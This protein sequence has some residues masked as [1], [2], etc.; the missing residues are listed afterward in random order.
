MTWLNTRNHHSPEVSSSFRKKLCSCSLAVKLQGMEWLG[1]YLL[2]VRGKV[3]TALQDAPDS[4]CE[5]QVCWR[6]G[7]KC[8]GGKPPGSCVH[9]NRAAGEAV[10]I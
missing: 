6:E 8:G 2:E 4:Q 10:C 3:R 5:H 1:K 7:E 9:C